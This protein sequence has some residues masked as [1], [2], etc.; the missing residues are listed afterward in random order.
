MDAAL[1]H[2]RQ[3]GVEAREEDVARLWPLSWEHVNFLGRFSF[4]LAEPVARGEMRP[5]LVQEEESP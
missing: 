3:T 5:L 1:N 4:A 2:L